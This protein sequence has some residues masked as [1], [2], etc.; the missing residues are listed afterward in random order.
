MGTASAHCTGRLSFIIIGFGGKRSSP[1]KSLVGAKTCEASFLLPVDEARIQEPGLRSG[2]ELGAIAARVRSAHRRSA[3]VNEI[4]NREK[5]S[6]QD[7][8]P[9]RG[10]ESFH[11][12]EDDGGV[13][14]TARRRWISTVQRKR[15]SANRKNSRSRTYTPPAGEEQDSGLRTMGSRCREPKKLSLQ[16]LFT[17][18]S[19]SPPLVFTRG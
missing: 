11:L 19:N 17:C 4:A 15:R 3:P 10:E 13:G 1:K 16:D 8:Y 2:G 6:L 14:L 18:T 9:P 5:I 12:G 7:L